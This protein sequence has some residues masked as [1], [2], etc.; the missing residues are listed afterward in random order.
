MGHAQPRADYYRQ[1]DRR[2]HARE[3][4]PP[5]ARIAR[6]L[7]MDRRV[8]AL[9]PAVDAGRSARRRQRAVKPDKRDRVRQRQRL[10]TA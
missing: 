5:P 3:I 10:D 4:H 7:L 6:C 9:L 8:P 1:F 2:L